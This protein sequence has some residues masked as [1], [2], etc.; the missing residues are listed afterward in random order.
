MPAA[1][2]N[3][4]TVGLSS[5]MKSPRPEPARTP[6]KFRMFSRKR[7][8]GTLRAASSRTV[9][10]PRAVLEVSSGP[11]DSAVGPTIRL[12]WTVG[13]TRTPLPMGPGHWKITR[14]TRVPSLLSSK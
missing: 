11:E 14:L 13:E 8:P 5:M 6:A 1:L 7:T 10:R 3:P 4:G 12:P 9:W 2:K